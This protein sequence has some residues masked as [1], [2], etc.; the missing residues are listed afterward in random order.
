MPL[1]TWTKVR[2]LRRPRKMRLLFISTAM[3]LWNRVRHPHA[4]ILVVQRGELF[5]REQLAAHARQ[6][7]GQHQTHLR[8]SGDPL[9]HRL[10]HIEADIATAYATVVTAAKADH[11]LPPAADWLLDNYYLVEE[12]IRTARRHLPAGYSRELPRLNQAPYVNY[13]RV[14]LIAQEIIAHTDARVDAE[15]TATFVRAWQE[16]S[17]L[18][19]GELWAI[20]IM[21]RLAVIAD[22]QQVSRH[23]ATVITMRQ[24]A[25]MWADKLHAV[26]AQQPSNLVVALSQL[27]TAAQN[28]SLLTP[29]FVAEFT[30]RLQGSPHPALGDALTWLEQRLGEKGTSVERLVSEENQ[31][32]TSDQQSMGNGI[33]SLKSLSHINWREFVETLSPV[34]QILRQDPAG[35]HVQM[36]FA[37]RDLYRHRI[38]E[39]A[40]SCALTEQDVA[41]HALM[42]TQAR[43]AVVGN[44]HREAHLGYYLIDAGQ[45]ALERSISLRRGLIGM[46]TNTL[47]SAPLFSYISAITAIVIGTLVI[48]TWWLAG[49]D[50]PLWGL[51]LFLSCIAL[52]ASQ[53]AITCV[54]WLV[55]LVIK[56]IS[57]PRVD[58]VQGITSD[59]RTLVII[60]TLIR[61]PS[62]VESLIDGL[63]VRFLANVDPNLDFALLT[64]FGD[65]MQEHLPTDA[66]LT[67]LAVDAIEELNRKYQHLRHNIFALFHRPRLFNKVDGNWLGRERKRGKIEDLNALL[68]HGDRSHFSVIVGETTQFS[69]YRFVITLDTDTQLPRDAARKLIGTLIHPLNRAC[70]SSDGR[71]TNGYVILQPR[72]AINLPSANRSWFARIFSGE[73]GLDPYSRAVSDV[74]QDLFGEGSFVGKGI[75]DIAAFDRA[76]HGRFPDN[77][78][79]SHDLI[80]GCFSRAGLVSDVLVFED[81]PARYGADVSRRQRWTR[82]DWQLLP[83]L[84]PTV[85]NAKGARVR[86]QLSLLARWKLFDNLRRGLIAPAVLALLLGSWLALPNDGVVITLVIILLLTPVALGTIAGIFRKPNDIPLL[87]HLRLQGNATMLQ[88]TQVVLGLVFLVYDAVVTIEAITI[89]LW[90]MFI[91]KRRKLEWTTA[92]DAE[93]NTASGWFGV[94]LAMWSAPA[95]ALFTAAFI[96][97]DEP[98]HV[99]DSI[100]LLLIWTASPIIAWFISRPIHDRMDDLSLRQKQFLGRV[101]RKTWRYYQHFVDADDHWLP[102]DNYQ[103][104]P[105]A[106]LARRTSPT[107]MGLGLLANLAAHDFG[108]M[109]VANVLE[110]CE[111]TLNSM[112][113]LERHRGHY[114]NWYDTRTAKAI[115]PLYVSMVDSG[116]LAGHLLVLRQGLI[117]M[118]EEPILRPQIFTGLHHT[119]ALVV[120]HAR[121]AHARSGTI[122][123]GWMSRIDEFQRLWV[124]L[125]RDLRKPP[126]Q[127]SSSLA[128]LGRCITVA[129]DFVTNVAMASD[130]ELRW[131]AAAFER[132]CR[133]HLDY[134]VRLAPWSR[135]PPVPEI[136]HALPAD[137]EQHL[138][139]LRSALNRL[140]RE[141]TLDD[142]AQLQ[143]QL[144][145]QLDWF[146]DE[147]GQNNDGLIKGAISWI[148]NL[149]SHVSLASERANDL[150]K[151]LQITGEQA[152]ALAMA[153]EWGFLFDRSRELFA[154][155]FNV[156]SNR[157]DNSYYDLLASEARLGSFVAIAQGQVPQDH[158]FKL[159]RLLTSTRA[160]PALLSWAG[161]M[162]EYLMPPLVMPTYPGT[163]LDQTYRAVVRRQIDYARHRGLPAWGMSESGYYL[164]DAQMNYQYRAFGVPGLGLK[165]G[166]ADDM[167]IAPYASA[168]ALL[169]YPREACANLYR[170][171]LAG[172]EGRYGFYEAIDYTPSRM[173]HGSQGS[174]VRSF[175]VHH[176]GMAFLAI[177]AV[178]N[179]RPMQRRFLAD[180]LCKAT[181]L[182]LQERIPKT[183]PV[184]YPHAA[185]AGAERAA[186]GSQEASMRVFTNPTAS[187]PHVHLLSNGRYHVMV[188]DAGGGY[189]RWQGQELT[190][191]REDVTRDADGSFCYIR[192]INSGNVWSTAWQPT[193]VK[194]D[195][196]EAVFQQGRAEFK[197]LDHQI[198]TRTEI[199]VSPEDDVELRRITLVNRSDQARII[200]V[201][202]YCE[203]VLAPANGDL[204]HPAFS[205]LFVMTK[206]LRERDAILC[207]RRPRSEQEQPP[208]FIHL[209]TVE[210][211]ESTPASYETS[212]VNFI[213]RNRTLAAPQVFD[214]VTPLS[215]T[216]GS[217]LD[218]ILSIRRTVVIQPGESAVINLVYAAAQ[219]ESEALELA[220]H[221]HEKHMTE[222]IIS[223]GWSHSQVV[224]GQLGASEA[225]AQLFGRLTGSVIFASPTHRASSA[226]L[227]ANKAGQSQLWSFGIS[228]DI[229]I[230]LLKIVNA[231]RLDLVRQLMNAHAYWRMKGLAVDLVIWNDDESVY[232][233]DISDRIVGV[234]MSGVESSMLDKPGGIFVRR[235]DLMSEDERILLQTVARVVL[236]DSDGSLA[237]FL[238]QR[239]SSNQEQPLFVPSRTHHAEPTELPRSKPT[240]LQF[241]NGV[242]GFSSDGREYVISVSAQRSTPAPW[243]NVIANPSFG[244]V[245][246]ESGSAYTWDGNSHEFR[247][248]PWSNDSVCDSGG[249]Y[250]HLRD[251]DTGACWSP[252][253]GPRGRGNYTIRHGFGYS[254]FQF[255]RAGIESELTVFVAMDAAVKICR[256]R[257]RNT[258]RRP[259]HLTL[260]GCVEWVLGE[261]RHRSSPYIVTEI[262][263]RHGGILARNRYN[264]DHSQRI[265]FFTCNQANRTFTGDRV[266]FLGRC[267]SPNKP[268]ALSH[269]RL[270][271]H[272]GPG[273]D[274]CAGMMVP[275]IL[276]EQSEQDII[277]LLGAGD[278]NDEI[279]ELI[280][281]FS[282]P[283]A[284]TSA[285]NEVKKYWH[286]H[287]DAIQIKTHDPAIDL[288]VNGWLPYQLLSCRL[289]A[290]SGFQQSGG[291]FG[292][293]DQLQDVMALVHS[294]PSMTRAHILRCAARQFTEGDVQHWW[295]PP[296]GRGVRTRISDDMLW[297][298]LAT[299]RYITVTHDY[300]ILNE[301]I[302]F[303]TGRPL[304]DN[305]ENYYD[306]P[307]V[308]TESES[309]HVHCVRAI[310]RCSQLGPHGLPLMGAGDWND[311]M[312]LVG[313]GGKGE[314]VWLGFF[315]IHVMQSYIPLAQQH[316]DQAFADRCL[317]NIAQ[318]TTHIEQQAW[319]GRWYKRAWF[320]DGTVMGSA[321]NNE[322]RIDALPQAW[323]AITGIGETARAH[324]A[325][326]SVDELLV[327]RDVKL[328]QVFDPPFNSSRP[329]P[330]YVQGYV[331]GVR[332]NGGQYTHAAI[333][334]IMGYAALGQAERAWELLKI[335]HP[336]YHSQTPTDI[337]RW[338]VEPYVV[339]AD[340]YSAAAHVGHGGWTWYT[341]SAGWLYRLITESLI[342]LQRFGNH[343]RFVPCVTE[344]QLPISLRYRYG[345]T[346]YDIRLVADAQARVLCDERVC[347]DG[348]VLL[349]DDGQAHQVV[350]QIIISSTAPTTSV[351]SL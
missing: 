288:F 194:P 61:K 270:S 53:C 152:G 62:D 12:Q 151:R 90:R 107:N 183:V 336:I 17:P 56:P 245:I 260:T 104:Y 157:L 173:A 177:D 126:K 323:A 9:R 319:D 63:E 101:A 276:A 132:E 161:S 169:V 146:L 167:V 188:T 31:A 232:R 296:Q 181:D 243:V 242:G 135:M 133:D 314:S 77:A 137:K 186:A 189:S 279:T 160:S 238:E 5:N 122:G 178:L 239:L 316:G 100:W 250:Y 317:A 295:H 150:T 171:S 257:I 266:E 325:M 87:M 272:V 121:L 2:I 130:E 166:L 18:T 143:E 136:I 259:R 332:E 273:L 164:T 285:L 41:A 43:C 57:L 308:S 222:R 210:G 60:P 313:V 170:M 52:A 147:F 310:K 89:T 322:C 86:N 65:A 255:Q 39:L 88:L 79:L 269:T 154:I 207:W 211:R 263:P 209:A 49:H 241:N 148:A 1:F 27:A 198:E 16:I 299:A 7:A 217:V 337:A 229:P 91:S 307:T 15:S 249:E 55:T 159:G 117:A 271:G 345:A 125:D 244:T 347:E 64:D 324:T 102:P 66:A 113:R 214:Q 346:F 92:S 248:T 327:K 103:E 155:G 341:G 221:Y 287:A 254:V 29:A 303:I 129:S 116:N 223:M 81:H 321:V 128:L 140:D 256:L 109:P 343:L 199:A 298:P 172:H 187:Q 162:F 145:P 35:I 82:G 84:L 300:G 342:G 246:S 195:N 70:F 234:I 290:R 268:A 274:P 331:P 208:W 240:D 142:I 141:I 28:G 26:V 306:L 47:R 236:T 315:L 50:I 312:N 93:R 291:A 311:G 219:K 120:E 333:W 127:L 329:S 114:Y 264:N 3:R 105:V 80:E 289:W 292:F 71:V 13:P 203:C 25:A 283:L 224:L 22:L 215:D 153:M 205:N 174:T 108:Y 196:Y 19:L 73:P 213:G 302:P 200:E 192:D 14:Y 284:V 184:V 139:R 48:A 227:S 67:K 231:E 75:Y 98:Y 233:Q 96:N 330:G 76:L 165:R 45:R 83:W 112:S 175:M 344:Q 11:R 69:T 33:T 115:T 34:E 36:D 261:Q 297:L 156:T 262:D 179:D 40:K 119:F 275:L 338:Q 72:A 99:Y 68:L 168:M 23:L 230:V 328:I 176:Q 94:Y 228:G 97:I 44:Q 202:S 235:A 334:T 32:Q 123:H 251:D 339:A 131:W 10:Y 349:C 309:L 54:N 305:E 277:F 253:P 51:G 58:L 220:S 226:I 304:R 185:E 138:V 282:E 106:V 301:Y 225:D 247:L 212:R 201:T 280:A 204:A 267:G 42:L 182:L 318:L 8:F 30:R 190:R 278:S 340:V 144:L 294:D 320:D 252:T 85:A 206:L 110:R 286:H 78:I 59:H 197:R 21:L 281:R 335:I 351:Q 348:N 237:Q 180:P 293:R 95:I 218:P 111:F 191:W 258:T 37:T 326:A 46:V 124:D 163:I 24:S 193:G 118:R 216:V 350:V 265:A 20:P 158:W 6:L 134:L 4:D 74:Y 38:E 149:R